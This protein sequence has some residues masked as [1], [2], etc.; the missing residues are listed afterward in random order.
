MKKIK[1]KMIIFLS[2]PSVIIV[3]IILFMQQSQFGKLPEG[4]LLDRIKNSPNYREGKFQNQS[5]TPDLAEDVSY[6]SVIK[7]A[8]FDR[9]KR[10]KPIVIIPSIKTDLKNLDKDENIIVWF[11]HSSYFMQL[12]G[13]KILVDPVFSGSASPLPYSVKSFKGTDIYTPDDF[14]EID[15]LFITHDHWDHLDY[16]TLLS[17]KP[18]TKK[19][20][21]GIGNSAHFDSWGFDKNIVLEGDWGDSIELDLGFSVVVTPGRHFSGRGFKRNK[22][23]WASF[24]F[25]S[26]TK[27]IF[28]GGD[29]GYDSH[30]AKIGNEHGPFD[31]ALLECGQYNYAW[32]YIHMMPEE[33]VLAATEL[34]AKVL[35]PVH[36]GKFALA[37]HAW[38]EPITRVVAEAHK[39]G[40]SIIHPLIGE[41]V[42]ID[43][44]TQSKQWWLDIE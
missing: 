6:F 40:Q 22:A 38:D 9:S 1:F 20:I 19:I 32:K 42:N 14:P 10:S 15:Y 4:K 41:K 7:K 12:D 28:I 18:K 36:W 21:T 31:L 16:K 30:F 37:L 44:S 27:K 39:T 24:V 23:I 25:K 35:F 8:I 5:F 26:P 11:G 34:K 33:T 43:A 3:S 29:S 13:K 2:I 17:L